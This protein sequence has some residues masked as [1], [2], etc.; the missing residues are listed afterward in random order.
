MTRPGKA[1]SSLALDSPL[2]ALLKAQP[3]V[4]VQPCPQHE[5]LPWMFRLAPYATTSGIHLWT[6]CCCSFLQFT[7]LD[8]NEDISRRPFLL[9]G[10]CNQMNH[11]I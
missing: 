3:G 8:E 4:V 1:Y 9:A 10:L 2:L 6:G 7:N 5:E 11:C